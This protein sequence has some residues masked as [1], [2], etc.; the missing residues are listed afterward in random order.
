MTPNT[1]ATRRMTGAHT[2]PNTPRAEHDFYATAPFVTEALLGVLPTIG[3]RLADFI[4]EPHVGQGGIA[5]VLKAAGYEVLAWDLIDRGYPGVR[6]HNFLNMRGLRPVGGAMS[7]V[8]NPPYGDAAA[9]VATALTLLE[10]GELLCALLRIQ[11][12][13]GARRQKLFINSPPRFVCVPIKRFVCARNAD[14]TDAN[15]LLCLPWF[16]WV[17]GFTGRPEIVWI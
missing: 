5:N 8:M 1:A 9:H 11:F 10:P 6:V 4:L 13:E 2:D 16:I 3:L 7:I 15:S 14:F 17:A 12:L